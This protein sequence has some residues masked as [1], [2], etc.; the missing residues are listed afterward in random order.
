MRGGFSGEV[1][2]RVGSKEKGFLKN[3][4]GNRGLEKEGS[5]MNWGY[6]IKRRYAF[7]NN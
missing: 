6:R 4:N 7:S 3:Q 5:V 2:G 1:W